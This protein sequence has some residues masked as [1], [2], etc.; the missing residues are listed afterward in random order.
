MASTDRQSTAAIDALEKALLD[1]ASAWTFAR[2]VGALTAIVLYR[3]GDPASLIRIRPR[4][5]LH[6]SLAEVV[7]VKRLDTGE[8]ELET[9]FLG[10]YGSSSP[11]PT[12]YTEELLLLE[13]EDQTSA[14]LFLDVIHQRLYQLF[15]ASQQKYDSLRSVV[16]WQQQRYTRLLDCFIGTRDEALQRLLPDPSQLLR[17]FGLF[18]QPRR[19]A[20]GLEVLLQDLLTGIPVRVEQ[21]AVR[22]VRV[23]AR[24]LSQLGVASCQ[25]GHNSLLGDRLIDRKSKIVIHVGPV[26]SATFRAEVT[27]PSHWRQLTAFIRFYL[28]T[29]LEVE[30]KAALLQQGSQGA[31]LGQSRWS[32]LGVDTWLQK[33]VAS[34]DEV[35]VSTLRIDQLAAV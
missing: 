26:D 13:Q 17:Y 14:R 30:L 3:G 15:A 24:H 5:S 4:L 1:D 11:L 21:C 6:S 20:Q 35:V 2:V 19:S 23:P 28:N 22:R 10:L 9:D 16:E 25:L 27:E 7:S 12:F 31:Q 33:Q 8:Y 34:A 18:S 29:P 32:Q